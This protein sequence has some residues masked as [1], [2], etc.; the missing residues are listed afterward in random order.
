MMSEEC[1][2]Y[3]RELRRL[4]RTGTLAAIKA[5]VDLGGGAT[6]PLRA[7]LR[8]A[9]SDLDELTIQE[10]EGQEIDPERWQRLGGE[11]SYLYWLAIQ[12]R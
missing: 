8:I 7:A 9:L 3:A 12:A 4:L 10:Q 1:A 11:L 5:T 2:G 6:L